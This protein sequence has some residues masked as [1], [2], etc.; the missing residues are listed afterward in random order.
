MKKRTATFGLIVLSLGFSCTILYATDID[1]DTDLVLHYSFDDFETVV[2]DDSGNGHIGL[3]VGDIS[4]EP[5]GK[6]NGGAHFF[7]TSGSYLDLNGPGFPAQN[8]PTSEITVAA[9]V[10]CDWTYTGDNWHHSIMNCEASGGTWCIYCEYRTADSTP[11]G[12]WRIKLQGYNNSMICDIKDWTL[13]QPFGPSGITPETWAHFVMT[14]NKN[15]GRVILYLNGQYYGDQRNDTVADKF[16]DLAG[17]WNGGARIGNQLDNFRRF[18]GVMDEFYLFKRALSHKDVAALMDPPPVVA[19]VGQ[20]NG[21]T[22]VREAKDSP[23]P[24][25]EDSFTIVLNSQPTY[26]VSIIVDPNT[27]TNDYAFSGTAVGEFLTLQFTPDD[28]DIPQTIIVQA[29]DDEELEPIETGLVKFH[30]TSNDPAFHK[31]YVPPVPVMILDDDSAGFL[32]EVGDGVTVKESG[33]TDTY[34]MALQYPPQ[35]P[36]IVEPRDA[37]EPNEVL[38]EPASLTFSATDMGPK[39]FTITAIDDDEPEPPN[40]AFTTTITHRVHSDD[41]TYDELTVPPVIVTIE[42]NDCG[43]WGYDPMDLNKDCRVNLQDIALFAVEFLECTLPYQTGCL[44]S[45]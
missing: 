21:S 20:T 44:R 5:N 41:L 22:R 43:A 14:Y 13:A 32:I 11:Y 25:G 19:T 1:I 31:G 29:V 42:D 33:L 28:W 8:I 34:S 27:N 39:I 9:W 12:F 26:P 10:K 15:T 16:V 4:P 23:A 37:S 24:A 6:I 30:L 45:N 40:A 38:I 2:P 35:Y 7:G 17:D 3:I 18:T 36:V